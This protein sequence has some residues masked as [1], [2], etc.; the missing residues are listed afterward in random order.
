MLS[1]FLGVG[2]QQG[3]SLVEMMIA[4][5]LG[6]VILLAVSD[7]FL[8][9]SRVRG[10]IE[11]TSRQIENGNYALRLFESELENAGYWGEAGA[12]DVSP[13]LPP[14]CP[15]NESD[16]NTTLGYPVQ[17]ELGAGTNC[18]NSKAGTDFIA[19]R[20][21]STCA[22]GDD[23][24]IDSSN[25]YLQVSACQSSSP[26][27]VILTSD[28]SKLTAKQRDCET[29]APRYGFLSRVY[30][31][32]D[33]NVL[34]RAELSGG[35]YSTVTSLVD[36]VESIHFEYGLDDSG[37]GIIDE[38]KSSPSGVEWSDVIAVKIYLI[39]R[40]SEPT[41]G[42]VDSNSYF[43]GDVEYEVPDA[44]KGYKRQLYS[45]TVSLRNVA[46]RRELP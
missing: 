31:V 45:T 24:C 8:K 22:I 4:M 21:A 30:Y 5:V 38:F 39:A 12:Q 9:D 13:S 17:G 6:L 3:F 41:S 25:Y 43:L 16:V 20:R 18:A 7:I 33:A 37:D 27:V 46:G 11:K 10:E 23:G 1:K 29:S 36:G 34:M 28:S 2:R 40:N 26:G 35:N 19:I 15:T 44:L 42:F 32:S 14:L